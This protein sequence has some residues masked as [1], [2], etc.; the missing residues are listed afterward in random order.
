IQ[1]SR[2]ELGTRQVRHRGFMSSASQMDGPAT[3]VSARDEPPHAARSHREDGAPHDAEMTV[4]PLVLIAVQYPHR[5]TASALT[6]PEGQNAE[7]PP[8]PVASKSE[9]VDAAFEQPEIGVVSAIARGGSGIGRGLN[10]TWE[11]GITGSGSD[12]KSG[13]LRRLFL[14]RN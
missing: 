6:V 12:R 10:G 5:A 2:V 14:P 1:T 7:L 11:S 8:A 9:T 4:T 13:S 3:G